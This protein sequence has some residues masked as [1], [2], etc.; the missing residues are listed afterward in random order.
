[1]ADYENYLDYDDDCYDEYD[2]ND[3][4]YA[5]AA[6]AFASGEFANQKLREAITGVDLDSVRQQHEQHKSG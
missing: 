3:P 1:M 2:A 5:D 4:E 6:D